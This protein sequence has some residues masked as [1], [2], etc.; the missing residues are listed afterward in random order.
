M[1]PVR[2]SKRQG[3]GAG[4]GRGRARGKGKGEGGLRKRNSIFLS[5]GVV[6]GKGGQSK[7]PSFI[8]I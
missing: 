2:V 4:G 7:C 1:C 6:N 8:Y 5:M 3:K